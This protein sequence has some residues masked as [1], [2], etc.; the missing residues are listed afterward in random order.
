VEGRGGHGRVVKY[1]DSLLCT[2][3][4]FESGHLLREVAVNDQ[5]CLENRISFV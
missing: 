5:F 1:Y 4:M 2:R 3:S